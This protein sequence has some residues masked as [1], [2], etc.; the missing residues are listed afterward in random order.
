MSFFRKFRDSYRELFQLKGMVSTALLVGLN[1]IIGFFFTIDIT[2][3]LKLGF[4]YVTTAIIGMLYGPVVGGLAGGV[5]D[6]IKFILRPT[7]PYHFGFTL[8]A[9]VSGMLFGLVLYKS[10]GGLV[11]CI[12]AKSLHTGIVNLLMN[13]YFLIILY[14]K[15][16]EVIFPARLGKNL[17]LLPLEIF[18]TFVVMRA[19]CEVEK[20]YP[21]R[22][23]V[24]QMKS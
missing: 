4:G 23:S 10:K 2:P 22:S 13:T 9:M 16:F 1:I 7:G 20:R 5:E 21:L 8:C 15:S 12:V 18:I 14:G 11:R 17:L 24:S 3:Q 6:V 19:F